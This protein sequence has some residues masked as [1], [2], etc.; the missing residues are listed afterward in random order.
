MIL[1]KEYINQ[2][3][4]E[5]INPQNLASF[6]TTILG[7]FI[8]FL[9]SSWQ[10]RKQREKEQNQL[11]LK[12]TLLIKK[13]L[14]RNSEHI[15][16]ILENIDEN[17]NENKLNKN[18]MSQ[19]EANQLK[20]IIKSNSQ[21]LDSVTSNNALLSAKRMGALKPIKIN[22]VSNAYDLYETIKNHIKPY[23]INIESGKILTNKNIYFT[24]VKKLR[25]DCFDLNN[26]F[27]EA[28]EK[29]TELER[30]LK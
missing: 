25:Q 22:E 1:L 11:E 27:E 6:V 18:N 4:T 19:K 3:I 24:I 14:V 29:I 5:L 7:V 28:I 2:L 26:I 23:Q 9:L 15:N 10:Y 20:E 8:G 21:Y 30:E 16:E 12:Y 13:E 17:F